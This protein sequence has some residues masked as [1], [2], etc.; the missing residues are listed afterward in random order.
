[1][2]FP[3]S[4]WAGPTMRSS[5]APLNHRVSHITVRIPLRNGEASCIRVALILQPPR[6]LRHK[7]QDKNAAQREYPLDERRRAPRLGGRPRTGPEGD[8]RRED[9]ADPVEV[10]ERSHA[11]GAETVIEGLGKV[12]AASDSGRGSPEAD[13]NAADDERGDVLGG[14]LNYHTDYSDKAALEHGWSST[15]SVCYY[16]CNHRSED[17]ADEDG[18]CI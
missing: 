14:C 1:M 6:T 3:A 18:G 12:D 8:A 4:E 10:V 17:A 7:R 5:Q 16:S 13:D 15:E 9:C 2:S 11:L